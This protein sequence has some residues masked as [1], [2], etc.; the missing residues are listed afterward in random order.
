MSKPP[1]AALDLDAVAEAR[2]FGAKG[3]TIVG[4]TLEEAFVLDREAPHVLAIVVVRARRQA[5]PDVQPRPDRRPL[6]PAV[7]GDGAW[8]ALGVAMAEGRTIAALPSGDD[9]TAT[10]TAVARL[11]ARRARWPDLAP[12]AIGPERDLGADQSNTSV[13]L[14]ESLLLKAYRRLQPGLNPDLEM[15]AFL[16]EEAAFPAVPRLAGFAEVVSQRD[17]ATTVAMPR[18]SST[19]AP[20]PSSR[21]PRRW[22]AGCWRPARSASSSRRR[23]PPTSGR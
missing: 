23:S 20:T 7:P 18:S 1:I 8:R 14:G 9:A 22:P 4:A 11:R 10:P 16:S 17:G 19:T 2:W 12:D 6:R 3:R 21:S 13:V 5:S 15:T